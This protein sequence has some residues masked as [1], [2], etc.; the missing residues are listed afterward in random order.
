MAE[1]PTITARVPWWLRVRLACAYRILAA[2]CWLASLLVRREG[3]RI[4]VTPAKDPCPP[5]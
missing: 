2:A 5:P 4:Q 1:T 3:I